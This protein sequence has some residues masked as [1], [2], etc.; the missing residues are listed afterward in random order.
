[1]AELDADPTERCLR[2]AHQF[3]VVYVRL[4]HG[5]GRWC[6]ATWNPRNHVTGEPTDG[7]WVERR[8]YDDAVQTLLRHSEFTVLELD[9]YP[10][11]DEVDPNAEG[12]NSAFA[13]GA[14]RLAHAEPAMI[15]ADAERDEN[16]EAVFDV[17][18]E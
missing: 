4:E 7:F 10:W 18:G 1:M 6:L 12:V 16:G 11:P 13:D 9:H 14:H 5:T 15:P 17:E 3:G 2:A 8:I